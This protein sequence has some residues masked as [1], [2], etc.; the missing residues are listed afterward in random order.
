MGGMYSISLP[1]PTEKEL[2]NLEKIGITFDGYRP[3]IPFF[4]TVLKLI[5]EPTIYITDSN[6]R[7]KVIHDG[8]KYIIL[9]E[10]DKEVELK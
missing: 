10:D 3:N 1:Y 4:W 5:Y 6:H 7:L 2:E 9:N 8:N